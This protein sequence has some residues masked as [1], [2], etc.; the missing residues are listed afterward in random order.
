MNGPGFDRRTVVKT[1]GI[2]A[3]VGTVAGCSGGDG[4]SGGGDGGDGDGGPDSDT[5]DA[6]DQVASY[7][8]L[9][10]HGRDWTRMGSDRFDDLEEFHRLVLLAINEL[11]REETDASVHSFDVTGT[12]EDLI[13]DHEDLADIAPGGVTRRRVITALNRLVDAGILVEARTRS[14][15]GKGRPAYSLAVDDATVVGEL[16]EDDRFEPVLESV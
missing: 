7:R 5:V 10:T 6:P 3:L 9:I 8:G 15:T 4:D 12:C 1:A 2:V 14:P 13:D 11:S 16:S